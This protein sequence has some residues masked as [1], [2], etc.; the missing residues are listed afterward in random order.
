VA[1]KNYGTG[2]PGRPTG[3]AP[4]CAAER[5]TPNGE[6]TV[7]RSKLASSATAMRTTALRGRLVGLRGDRPNGD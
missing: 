1:H 6:R 2:I 5:Q 4:D 3:E 7:N